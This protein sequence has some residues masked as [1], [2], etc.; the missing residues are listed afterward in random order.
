[1]ATKPSFLS[2]ASGR[3]KPSLEGRAIK[4][5]PAQRCR[6]KFLR[7]FPEGFR[8]ETYLEW[9]RNY[10]WEAHQRFEELLGRDTLRAMLREGEF[11]E[12]ANRAVRIES[13]TNLLFSFEKMAVRDA[14]KTPAAAKLFAQGLY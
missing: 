12:A 8:D 10:K 4:P 7:Y 1:M 3:L 6:R 5:T 14:V 9:E 13:R 11:V 2:R